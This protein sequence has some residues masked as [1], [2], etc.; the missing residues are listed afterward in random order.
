MALPRIVQLE[1]TTACQLRCSFCPRTVLADRWVT[2]HLPWETFSSLLP[3]VRRTGLVHLQGWGEPLL[4]PHLWDMAAAIKERHGRVSLTTNALLLDKAASHEACRIG[5]NLVAIS[6]AGARAETND[7]LR[8]GSHLDQICANVSYLCQLKPRPKVNLVMQMMK[9]TLE[10]LPEL[11]T[12]A[13]RLGVD[14]VVAPNLDYIPTVEVDALRAFSFSPDFHQI[15]LINEAQTKGKELGVKVRIYPLRPSSDILMCDADPVH[16]VWITVWGEVAPCPYLALPC[17]GDFPRLF[18]G[19][20]EHLS[21][22]SFG[23]VTEGLD[24]VVNSQSARSFR[25]AFAR[26]LQASR[27]DTMTAVALS[28]MPRVRSTSGAFLEPLAET[29]SLKKATALLPPPDLCR[30]CYKFY[31]L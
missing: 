1:V 30:N 4:H 13:A 14:G 25:E 17:R 28:A 22:F 27:L 8:V 19:K 26:R 10:E 11:V 15:E 20:Q 21:R 12:L 7:S 24:R 31:G 23:R 9:P 2:A 16:N 5:V 29:K 18:W 6:V 3:F